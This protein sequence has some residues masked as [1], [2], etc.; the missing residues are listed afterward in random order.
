MTQAEAFREIVKE[1]GFGDA[2]AECSPR[3]MTFRGRRST[4]PAAVKNATEIVFEDGSIFG[5]FSP[6]G[7][8]TEKAS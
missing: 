5:F 2:L 7:Y 3:G 6:G 8:W 4:Y 1:K